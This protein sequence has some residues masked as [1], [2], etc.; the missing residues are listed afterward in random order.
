MKMPRDIKRITLVEDEPDLRA[1][2]ALVLERVGGWELDL[3]AD[4]HEAVARTEAFAPD[5]ILMDVM[6]P[7]LDGPE[8]LERLRAM[9]TL[10]DTPAVFMTAKAQ[11]HEID[12]LLALGA[13]D[14]FVKPFEP[15]TLCDRIRAVWARVHA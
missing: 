11:R 9:P 4:G 5:L 2:C 1:L 10:T 14:V 3:C 7:G 6:M 12:E 13:L 8:T 15:M